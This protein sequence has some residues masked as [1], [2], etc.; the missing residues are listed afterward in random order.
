MKPRIFYI[1]AL[2]GIFG[3]FWTACD[4]ADQPLVLIDKQSTTDDLLDSIFFVDSVKVN[5][6]QVLLEE[7]T[8]HKCVNCAGASIS[9]HELSEANDH[10]LIIYGVHAGYYS[11]PDLTGNYTTDFRC[12]P[13]DELF[14]YFS[15][16]A[17]PIGT[18]NRVE[19][20]GSELISEGNWEAA[21]TEE[22]AKPNLV[23][24]KVMNIYYPNLDT[25]QIK[26]T[27]TFHQALEGSYKLVVYV[28][29]DHIIS[30]QKNNEDAVGPT[31][32]WLDYEHRNIL[33]AGITPTYGA[34]IT[35]NDIVAEMPYEQ[36]FTYLLNE[37][38]VTANCNLIVYVIEEQ[39]LE[40]LQ[41]AE[42][43]IKTE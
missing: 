21:V 12:E 24:L 27:T 30:P 35:S 8:G 1:I 29:E 7:F 18:V 26:V 22:L 34:S 40:V 15:I 3:A 39:S 23:D 14:A 9:A 20:S 6:K 32:D 38:W 11:E 42:L 19:Y 31:P 10:K 2:L 13:G 17:N 25:I 33:R 41:V 28:A 4:K 5:T 43:A 37:E 36:N 16:A